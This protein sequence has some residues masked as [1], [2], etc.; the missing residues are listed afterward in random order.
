M[1]IQNLFTSGKMN[2]DLDERLLP[3]GEYRDALNVKVA[4]SVGSDVGAIEN[5]LSNEV[6]TSLNFGTNPSCIGAVADD[7]NKKIY[8]FVKSDTGSYIAEYSEYS[9]TASFVLQDTRAAGSNVLNFKKHKLITGVNVLINDTDGKVFI[10]WT[11]NENPPRYVEVTEGKLYG[12]NNFTEA[13]ISV[14]KAPPRTEPSIVLQIDGTLDDNYIEDKFF[15]FAYRYKYKHNKFSALSP[16]SEVAFFPNDDDFKDNPY[17][18]Y[19]MTNKFNS[20]QITYNSGPS[21]VLEIEVYAKEENTANNFLIGKFNKADDTLSDDTNYQLTF[22]N[23]KIYTVLSD[24]QY[25]RVYDN[26]P[27]KAAAQDFLGNR[28]V[29]G[30][31]EENYDIVDPSDLTLDIVSTDI[32]S[33]CS[34]NI[35]ITI[36]NTTSNDITYNY[37]LCNETTNRQGIARPGNNVI[38]AASVVAQTGL[39]ITNGA[40]C[41]GDFTPRKTLKS[42]RN[43]VV[44]LVYFDSNGR[45]SSVIVDESKHV[46]IPFGSSSKSNVLKITINNPAPI[47][48]DRYKIA[49]KEVKKSYVAVKANGYAYVGDDG[50]MYIQI[51]EKEKNKLP[52]GS[53]IIPKHAGIITFNDIDVY[54]VE[55]VKFYQGGTDTSPTQPGQ[56]G[57]IKWNSGGSSNA[58]NGLYMKLRGKGLLKT[59][60]EQAQGTVAYRTFEVVSESEQDSVFYEVPGTYNITNGFHSGTL[61]NQDISIP[62]IV[63]SQAF[64]A[65]AFGYAVES[66]RIKDDITLNTFNLGVRLNE[67][68]ELYKR[69][70]RIA[71]LTY[72]DVYEES[73]SYNGLNVF[74]L[75]QIN[76]KDIDEKYG[77]IKKL[78][79]RDSDLIVFQQNKIHRILFNKNVLFTASGTG[80][81]SQSL[82]I[83]GQEV[84]YI[85]EYGIS[86]SPESFQSWGSR[87]YFSDERRSAVLRLSQDGITEISEY[88]MRS[89][90]NDNLNPNLNVRGI[91]GYDPYLDQYVVSVQDLPV[92]WRADTYECESGTTTTT[93]TTT[94][95]TTAAPTTTTTTT[96]GPTTTTTTTSGPFARIDGVTSGT[97]GAT[98]TLTGEDLNFTGSSWAWTG[99]AAAGLTSKSINITESS[100]GN[101]TYGVTIDGTYSDTHTVTWST[102]TTTS[103]TSTTT[104]T[105]TSTTTT[106]TTTAAP[107]TCYN[108]QVSNSGSDVVVFSYTACNGSSASVT[109]PSGQPAQTICAQVN[110]VTMSP[111]TGSIG[112]PQSTC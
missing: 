28:I 104:T 47:W 96:S 24:T 4:N 86:N 59:L 67:V 18:R 62:A 25:N 42:N 54:E 79:S 14:I 7:K 107:V 73:T 77:E 110:T 12:A 3:Q 44:G 70:K 61:Q 34:S 49:V 23:N 66:N 89:W 65:F 58:E 43:Y 22:S 57:E 52:D 29:Y 32:A 91:G 69:N 71:S 75:T 53:K 85:G 63:E 17:D 76:Y 41:A 108:Y 93:S 39:T 2:K 8:W 55:T 100:S 26:V 106:T 27:L 74:N 16:F 40:S 84:P 88:G 15:T 97:V 45:K 82:N 101:V 37:L 105:T 21:Q 51:D 102:T 72:S 36:N 90:F 38:C 46:N 5:A 64:N 11:D 13:D 48:A 99:G 111:A 68:V 80:D 20:V 92:E 98:I 6:L 30:N 87:M 56:L 81:V 10:Y 50:Y 83:L 31:Y 19:A 103:T 60:V 33:E 95:T 9:D 94:T 1:K 35:S 78:H 109:I 112:S